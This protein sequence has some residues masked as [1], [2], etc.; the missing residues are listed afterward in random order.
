MN[1]ISKPASQRLLVAVFASAIALMVSGT[2]VG[3]AYAEDA[4]YVYDRAKMT[5]ELEFTEKIQKAKEEYKAV[6]ED[7]AADTE[8]KKHA[9]EKYDKTVEDAKLLRDQKI[10]QARQEYVQATSSPVKD[11]KQVKTDFVNAINNAKIEYEKQLTDARNYYAE[12][13]SEITNSKDIKDLKTEYEKILDTLKEIY[14]DA[15]ALAQE[16][17]QGSLKGGEIDA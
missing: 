2:M 14:N 10:E 8:I 11:P 12:S 5:A 4:Q 17:Y 9:K 1:E 15:I 7:T 16:Q 13:L 3:S 6:V